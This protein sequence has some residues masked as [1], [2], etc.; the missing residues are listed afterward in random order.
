MF[1]SQDFIQAHNELLSR[2]LIKDDEQV[3]K[4]KDVLKALEEIERLKVKVNELEIENR[5]LIKDLR[6]IRNET[7]ED[8]NKI[9]KIEAILSGNNY[10]Y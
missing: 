9:V 1:T 10:M 4:K 5:T 6:I 7:A 2:V 3:I 8:R